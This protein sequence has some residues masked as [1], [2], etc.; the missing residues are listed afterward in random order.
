MHTHPAVSSLT[1]GAELLVPLVARSSLAEGE[2]DVCFRDIAN[3][4]VA[5]VLVAGLPLELYIGLL[6]SQR[7]ATLTDAV[8][9]LEVALSAAAAHTREAA[10]TAC[11][12]KWP[13]ARDQRPPKGTIAVPDRVL[14]L[15][16][17]LLAQVP[18]CSASVA[19]LFRGIDL[20]RY[21]THGCVLARRNVRT[22]SLTYRLRRRDGVHMP[23]VATARHAHH[24]DGR[25]DLLSAAA[26]LHAL[27]KALPASTTYRHGAN[28][29]LALHFVP[30]DA[31]EDERTVRPGR[32]PHLAAQRRCAVLFTVPMF[33]DT[34][35]IPATLQERRALLPRFA[36]F[37]ALYGSGR[38]E[39]YPALF[40]SE[41][42]T[43]PVHLGP[44]GRVRGRFELTF[45]KTL[46]AHACYAVA[47][48]SAG[49][50]A[51][52][53][54]GRFGAPAI[55]RV[56]VYGQRMAQLRL[57]DGETAL[58]AATKAFIGALATTPA[59]A[60]LLKLAGVHT[61]ESR[62]SDASSAVRAA[63]DAAAAELR[64][65]QLASWDVRLE[66]TVLGDGLV[67]GLHHLAAVAA[68]PPSV[69]FVHLRAEDLARHAETLVAT[70]GDRLLADVGLPADRP[71]APAVIWR[72]IVEAVIVC[73]GLHG[74]LNGIRVRL[75][76]ADAPGYTELASSIAD[77]NLPRLPDSDVELQPSA[78]ARALASH[79]P[80][81]WRGVAAAVPR[82][83]A[84]WLALTHA[85]DDADALAL[86]GELVVELLAHDV[87][88]RASYAGLAAQRGP[89]RGA[90][91]PALTVD[92]C[93]WAA[94]SAASAVPVYPHHIADRLVEHAMAPPTPNSASI[95]GSGSSGSN[96]GGGGGGGYLC[97]AAVR[98][99][100][101]HMANVGM[102]V[103]GL[104]RALVRQL[105]ATADFV[106]AMTAP[107]R[108]GGALFE[109]KTVLWTVRK[110]GRPPPTVRC[111]GP[112]RLAH[113][114]ARMLTP[115]LSH[116]T[117]HAKFSHRRRGRRGSSFTDPIRWRPTARWT[118]RPSRLPAHPANSDGQ[119][120]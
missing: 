71:T 99:V 85:T 59:V 1:F 106:W 21:A 27:V 80:P 89:K 52:Y 118:W 109:P 14:A 79:G 46:N 16:L 115:T 51:V 111:Q 3:Q 101:G 70:I 47:H 10:N 55:A 74:D 82:F 57:V 91:P 53:K 35:G 28:T 110:S 34:E 97:V 76:A 11:W 37:Q 66:V 20:K 104:R 5:T 63:L 6:T 49:G 18:T 15:A 8:R 107:G 42:G 29:D 31:Y 4:R 117:L 72:H 73:R 120:R 68:V 95:S 44:P 90:V 25:R 81:T 86:A 108:A 17:A 87:H 83:A 62:S 67:H 100:L 96:G 39:V 32:G 45:G 119:F 23:H 22:Q 78:L 114:F 77:R 50:T 38:F 103:D 9:A 54:A 2:R 116:S 75:G 69:L 19:L 56:K 113:G 65:Y 64:S 48:P 93:P 94:A 36:F 98:F 105:R 12:P 58:D 112:S 102:D 13:L 33:S 40:A 26:A 92:A 60:E 41:T 30:A 7:G 61:E 88:R 43:R 84:R 24:L